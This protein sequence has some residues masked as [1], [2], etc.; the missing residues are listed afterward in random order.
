VV[1]VALEVDGARRLVLPTEPRGLKIKPPYLVDLRRQNPGSWLA[2]PFFTL[3][4]AP[5]AWCG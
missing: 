3:K 5:A 4:S 2:A 1:I